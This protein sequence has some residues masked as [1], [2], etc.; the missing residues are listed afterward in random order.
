MSTGIEVNSEEEIG[1]I[2]EYTAD[3]GSRMRRFSYERITVDGIT[4]N[5]RTYGE[6]HVTA[7]SMI[8]F[9]DNDVFGYEWE[10]DEHWADVV[11]VGNLRTNQETEIPERGRSLRQALRDLLLQNR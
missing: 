1:E 2:Y 10:D 6:P 9:K 7:S 11:P 5:R 4:S 3:D 8:A